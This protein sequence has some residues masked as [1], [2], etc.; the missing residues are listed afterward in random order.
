MRV[1]DRPRAPARATRHH[2]GSG[3]KSHWQWQRTAQISAA[4][5]PVANF[6]PPTSRQGTSFRRNSFPGPLTPAVTTWRSPSVAGRDGP[7]GMKE[8]S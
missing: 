8:A 6:L 5:S 7:R 3:G 2:I 4:C 1:R